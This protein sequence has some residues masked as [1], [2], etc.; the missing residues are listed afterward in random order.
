MNSSNGNVI[1]MLFSSLIPDISTIPL[2]RGE[3]DFD[4]MGFDPDDFGGEAA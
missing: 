1:V 3:I 4:A 2:E